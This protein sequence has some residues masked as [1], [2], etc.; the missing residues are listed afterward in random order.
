MKCNL[1]DAGIGVA[2][3]IK[4]PGNPTAGRATDALVSHIDIF[5]TLCE[6]HGLEVPDWLAGVSLL[7]VLE[8]KKE[9][10]NDA[11]YSEVTYHASYEPMRC[12]RTQRYKLIRRFD[13]HLGFVPSNTDNGHSKRFL[14]DAGIMNRPLS[15]E[16]LFDLYLDPME[17]ENLAGDPAYLSIYNDLSKRLLDWME[18]TDDPLLRVSYRVPLPEG[19]IANKLCCVHLECEDYE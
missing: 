2:L 12:I 4:Y 13:Y 5:P 16:M 15:R 8:G 11:V 18:R 14:L 19:A 1:Y 10:V 3:M 6:I 9:Q 17:R 7:K